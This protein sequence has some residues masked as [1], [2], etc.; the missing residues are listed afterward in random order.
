MKSILPAL[1][2]LGALSLHAGESKFRCDWSSFPQGAIRYFKYASTWGNREPQWQDRRT[3]LKEKREDGSC[4]IETQEKNG[5]D[6]TRVEG[7]LCIGQ[8]PETMNLKLAKTE[9]EA[10]KV[11]ETTVSCKK[12]TY[13]GKDDK[14]DLQLILWQIPKGTICERTLH[15]WKSSGLIQLNA[16][17]VRA[18]IKRTDGDTVL[19]IESVV[20]AEDRPIQIAKDT[21][22]C[23]EERIVSTYQKQGFPART[24]TST[25]WLNPKVP[26]LMVKYL[27]DSKTPCEQHL[28]TAF[29]VGTKQ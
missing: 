29:E 18:Q 14:D 16:D 5:E 22:N 1:L 23:L 27:S 2:F 25:R 8:A 13:A 26:G 28:T 9:P 10:V 17:V 3:V 7:S 15:Q 19:T 24:E 6:W 11:G 12:V 21:L 20:I 4:I